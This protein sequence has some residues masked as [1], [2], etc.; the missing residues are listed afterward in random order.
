MDPYPTMA[1]PMTSPP[2]STF[3][4]LRPGAFVK[5]APPISPDVT[6]STVLSSISPPSESQSSRMH[7]A[8][9]AELITI[10]NQRLRDERDERLWDANERPPEYHKNP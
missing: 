9:T 5:A 7:G 3:Q 8:T 1:P 6:E 10:L 4:P 2:I